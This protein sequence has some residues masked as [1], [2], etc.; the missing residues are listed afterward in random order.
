[1]LEE[2]T[3]D[4]LT[5]VGGADGAGDFREQVRDSNYRGVY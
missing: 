4:I 1:M 3:S 5:E 2:V